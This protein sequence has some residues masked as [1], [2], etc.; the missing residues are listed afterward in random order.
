MRIG[1]FRSVGHLTEVGGW[2]A[3]ISCALSLSACRGSTE[4]DRR[5]ARG[6]SI[7]SEAAPA[8]RKGPSEA[9]VE[10]RR[11]MFERLIGEIR[12]SHVFS[13][14]WPEHEWERQ[15]PA[16]WQEVSSAT[17]R[18]ALWRAL[19]HLSNSLRDGHLKFTP[20]GTEEL[21]S[22]VWLPFEL[23]NAGSSTR[24]RLTISRSER[25]REIGPGDELLT[26][27]GVPSADLLEHFQFEL[28]EATPGARVDQLLSFLQSRFA[29]EQTEATVI[30][31]TLQHGA[32]VV[33]AEASF[34]PHSSA[35]APA[36]D[37]VTCPAPPRTFGGSYELL[38]AGAAV[39]LYRASRE[40]FASHPIIR[41]LSFVSSA[42]VRASDHQR[43]EAFLAATPQVSGVLLDLRDNGGGAA[44]DY[45]LPWY[46]PGP[47]RGL[48]E[49]I[50][51]NPDLTDRARLRRALRGDAAVDEYLRRAAGRDEW[52]VRPFDCGPR[53][54]EDP[55][56]TRLGRVTNAPVALLL[57]PGCK[58][59]CDT[60][61]AIWSRERFGPMVGT[62]PAAM[63]TSLRYPLAVELDGEWLGDFTTAL[64]GLRWDAG[65][66]WLEGQP[67]PMDTVVEPSASLLGNELALIEGAITAL[68]A[69]PRPDAHAVVGSD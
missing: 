13:S 37:G 60:F 23:I 20:A 22:R 19:R 35:S 38:E 14:A 56:R 53:G 18:V 66:P 42:E 27:D 51:L 8:R 3:L 16:L 30:G 62:P 9:E 61:S 11:A 15:L 26:Y 29:A 4:A 48:K 58:S 41:H 65:D 49:W 39:C 1:A 54:C 69:W 67:L 25:P 55:Q 45:V 12:R 40:P 63:Y 68:R 7:E 43:V 21:R 17:S 5:A 31:L 50:R 6:D 28:N 33:S 52:W 57:G 34:G 46:A 64:C 24:P 10:L 2:A 44:A 36:G 47:H 59:A 32:H